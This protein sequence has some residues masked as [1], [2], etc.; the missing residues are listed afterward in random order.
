MILRN[1]AI[2]ATKTTT[3]P[4]PHGW[5]FV[6]SRPPGW[7]GMARLRLHVCAEPGCPELTDEPRCPDHTRQVD[8]ARGTR[9]QRGYDAAYDRERKRW[10]PKVAACTVHCHAPVCLMTSGRLILP[11]QPWDLGHDDRRHI[12]GPEHAVCNRSAGGKAAHR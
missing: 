10:A 4:R 3:R 2:A 6:V 9:Q 11:H 1:V 5:A 7:V 8:R 12:R